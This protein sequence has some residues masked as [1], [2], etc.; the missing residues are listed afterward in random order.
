LLP[1]LA[2]LGCSTF[3]SQSHYREHARLL[4]EED[5]EA[6]ASEHAALGNTLPVPDQFVY[7]GTV[8]NVRLWH[9]VLTSR[10]GQALMALVFG[11]PLLLVDLAGSLA[12]DSVLLPIGIYEQLS[13]PASEASKSPTAPP[14]VP[15]APAGDRGL[16]REDRD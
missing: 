7:G 6:I 10:D 4:A 16:V 14:P 1:L 8:N 15:G 13:L 11:G 12:A 5:A 9:R 2:A 3:N